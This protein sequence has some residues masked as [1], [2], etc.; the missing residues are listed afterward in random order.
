MTNLFYSPKGGNAKTSS[1]DKEK[2]KKKQKPTAGV[3][4]KRGGDPQ[5]KRNGH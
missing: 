1:Q 3:G 2:E 5:T 4:R